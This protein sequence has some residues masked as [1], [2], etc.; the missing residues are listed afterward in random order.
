MDRCEDVAE[1]TEQ[2]AAA[3]AADGGAARRGCAVVRLGGP[4][5]ARRRDDGTSLLPS[6]GIGTMAHNGTGLT[7]VQL[8]FPAM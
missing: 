4:G 6:P 2:L 1:V 5:I 8:Q 7:A 3:E